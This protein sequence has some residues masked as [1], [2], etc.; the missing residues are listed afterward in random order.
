M[1]F[2]KDGSPVECTVEEAYYWRCEKWGYET[3]DLVGYGP[4]Q[5]QRLGYAAVCLW[6]LANEEGLLS[7]EDYFGQVPRGIEKIL[8]IGTRHKQ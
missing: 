2:D 7:P 8:F 5:K 6:R 4:V 3:G 1:T